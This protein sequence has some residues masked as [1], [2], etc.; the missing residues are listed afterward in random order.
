MVDGN[1]GVKAASLEHGVPKREQLSFAFPPP[2]EGLNNAFREPPVVTFEIRRPRKLFWLKRAI[3]SDVNFDLDIEG[4]P[5][6]HALPL[7]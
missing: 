7:T 5:L 4:S 6:A 1:F 3:I 2:R